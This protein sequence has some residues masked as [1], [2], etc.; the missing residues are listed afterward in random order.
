[1]QNRKEKTVLLMKFSR[2]MVVAISLFF[3]LPYGVPGF[4][5]DPCDNPCGDAQLAVGDAAGRIGGEVVIEVTGFTGCC[6]SG[7]SLGIGHD[8]SKL[9]FVSGEAGPFLVG[10]AGGDLQFQARGNEEEGYVAIY[11]FFDI[12]FPITVDPI[13]I[14][15]NTV[16]AV[17]RY[18]ILPGAP[19][20]ETV[21]VNSS[22]TF[23]SP[24]PVS[25][26]YS[27]R[28]GEPPLDPSLPDGTITILENVPPVLECPAS[29]VVECTD[30]AGAVVNYP[31]SATDNADPAPLLE[32]LPPSGS[33]L[34]PGLHRVLCTATDA[35][36]NSAECEFTV[37]VADTAAPVI[38][39]R[40]SSLVASCDLSGLAAGGTRVEFPLPDVID[41][42]DDD[43]DVVCDPPSGSIFP[44]GTTTVTCVATDNDGNTSSC[45]FEVEVVDE[46]APVLACPEDIVVE[47]ASADGNIVDYPL[48]LIINECNGEPTLECDPPSGTL[49]PLGTTT[50]LCRATDAAGNS[51]T[52]TFDVTLRRDTTA[53]EMTCPPDLV[54]SAVCGLGGLEAGGA[55]VEFPLPTVTD[56]CD[57]D[58]FVICG[59]PSGSIFPLGRTT[60]ICMARDYDGNISNCLFTVDVV[61]HTPP[62]LECVEDI[63]VQCTSLDGARVDYSPP[64]VANECAGGVVV[65]CEPP[66]GTIFAPG[67]TTV[68]CR[69]TDGAGNSSACAFDVTVLCADELRGD[70]NSDG[71]INISD[72]SFTL[73][74]LYTGGSA[75]PC[76]A[77]ADSSGNSRI[78]V[79]DVVFTLNYLF[80]G[81]TDHPVLLTCDL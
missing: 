49:F 22:R 3:L 23:G 30:P 8:N 33:V 4:A 7:L 21:L 78:N 26:V 69:V 28:P 6:V 56:D 20:G 36:G 40:Q 55:R 60:V 76:L 5:G 39:C 15:D 24:N 57:D 34:S 18:E 72:V 79:A 50:V 68:R 29:L 77:A 13:P 31:V 65:I 43:V 74:Y 35:A 64:L 9:R 25:N 16:L 61:D 38:T 32:C 80:R 42:C 81:G 63:V 37:T 2:T 19:L 10:H 41:D 27:R 47:C 75:P 12:S 59:P 53:P 73:R 52:C 14:P 1:M 67:T 71:E 44:M 51:G 62:E 45:S 48:P 70:S 17:L 58:V 54:V 11:A 66:S 46:T